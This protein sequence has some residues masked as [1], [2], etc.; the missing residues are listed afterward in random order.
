MTTEIIIAGF[1]GQGIQSMGKILASAGMLT[2]KKVSWLPSYGPE[3]RGGTSNCHVIISD[4]LIGSPILNECDALIAMNVP[5]LDKFEKYVVPGGIIILDSTMINHEV[6]RKDVKTF[7]LPATQIA[8]EYE[9]PAFAGIVLLGKLLKETDV[10]SEEEFKAGLL[11]SLPEKK[12]YL[13]PEEMNA[14]K[15]GYSY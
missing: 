15:K 7:K 12:H 6:K 13:V 11:Y 2:D 3:M 14:L 8:L 10:V 5:S 1:G 4:E 9:N